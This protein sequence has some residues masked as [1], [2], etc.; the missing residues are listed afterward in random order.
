MIE[1]HAIQDDNFSKRLQERLKDLVVAHEI[2]LHGSDEIERP[3]IKEGE[4][5]FE[6]KEEIEEWFLQLE[7][8]LNWQRS[9]SGD[10]CYID[11]DSGKV[12]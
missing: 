9:I 7:K 12:C 11:P 5:V 6:S 1:L 3:F 4:Q 2:I 8:E 10:G